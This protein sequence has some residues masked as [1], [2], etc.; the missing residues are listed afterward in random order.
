MK[1]TVLMGPPGAGKS[2]YAAEN[3]KPGDAV[4]DFDVIAQALGSTADHDAPPTVGKLT[5][6]A[7]QAAIARAFDSLTGVKDELPGD[8]WLLAVDVNDET[9]AD[10]GA[11]GA[12]FVTLDPGKD[13]VL[14]RLRADGRPQSSIDAAEEWYAR[15]GE[16]GAGM[17]TKYKVAALTLTGELEEGQFTG[18]ASVF[19]NIDS[20]G[21]I[22]VKGAFA[23]SLA[24]FGENGAG[25]PVYWS[26]RM[27]DPH[28]NIGMTVS[29]IEDEHGLKVTVQLDLESP[30]GAY[31]HKLIKQ[32]RVTQMSFAYD[33]LEAAEVKVEDRWAY[34]LRKLK[35][36]EISVVPVGANQETELLAVKNG[37][38]PRKT[39]T[40]PVEESPAGGSS[41]QG[42]ADEPTDERHADDP[43]T[44]KEDAK[45]QAKEKRARALIQIALATAGAHHGKDS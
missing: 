38:P 10:W 8:V 29:A 25:I 9:R 23:E 42:E 43:E 34:E 28:M 41:E 15:H 30:T 3:R 6:A 7:R 26:H 31:V 24:A 16:K 19:C 33:V 17:V 20:Y 2:T 35:V 37:E 22:V 1:L 45:V 39:N 4:I 36:H 44:D 32:G 11:K 5:F 40:D 21:D 13:V 14:E 12:E 27:D 18:Y